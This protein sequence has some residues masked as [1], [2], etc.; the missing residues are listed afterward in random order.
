MNEAD[1]LAVLRMQAL[2]SGD[3]DGS[4]WHADDRLRASEAARRT[5][6]TPAN[7]KAYVVTRARIVSE[8]LAARGELAPRSRLAGTRL[9]LLVMAVALIAGIAADFAGPGQRIDL[10]SPPWLSVV[11]WNLL[12]YGALL[13][14]ALRRHSAVR[15]PLRALAAQRL[16]RL[17]HLGALALAL[18]LCLGL[19]AR[20]LVLDYR[21]AWQSTFLEAAQVH[22]L[23]SVVLAPA[24]A[25]SGLQ[26]PDVETIA[27]LRIGQAGR[28]LPD[29]SAASWIHLFA[30]SLL[31]IVIV[32]RTLLALVASWRVR[33]LSSDVPL[34]FST[35][36]F[37]RLARE[38]A[39]PHAAVPVTV[40]PYAVEVD[41]IAQAA[42][43]SA[44]ESALGGTVRL[45]LA[46]TLAFGSED[47][48]A[49]AAPVAT[50]GGAVFVLFALTAT[51]EHEHHGA[52]LSRIADQHAAAGTLGVLLD[53]SGFRTR[54][55]ADLQRIEQRRAAWQALLAGHGL[56]PRF[57]DLSPAADVEVRA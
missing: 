53:E 13:L 24:S 9:P 52:L 21:A 18:G 17:L 25:L 51:P 12:A 40:I 42:L 32:P 56:T 33:Q 37:Q 46:P 43:R 28:I 48:L 14:L 39:D 34:D 55:A 23:L 36:Y 16:K 54:F 38:C 5:A 31:L 7:W 19:Y 15:D 1:A 8:Q 49:L 29:V 10:L 45:A 57:V 26:V 50:A 22:A 3:P 20:G 30:L 44:L 47:S 6:G 41:A 2:E 35:P 11:A 27:A 4:S